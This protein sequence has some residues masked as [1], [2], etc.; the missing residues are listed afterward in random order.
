[1]KLSDL[2]TVENICDLRVEE[3]RYILFNSVIYLATICE[4]RSKDCVVVRFT[5]LK[6]PFRVTIPINFIYKEKPPK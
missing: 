2:S 4:I 1:M 6:K 3:N 5:Y